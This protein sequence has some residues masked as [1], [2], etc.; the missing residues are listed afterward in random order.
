MSHTRPADPVAAFAFV[1]GFASVASAQALPSASAHPTSG[2]AGQGEDKT[3]ALHAG[4]YSYGVFSF[5]K[6]LN[7][8]HAD[9]GPAGALG[10][11]VSIGVGVHVERRTLVELDAQ[12]AGAFGQ[13]SV[14][15]T[16]MSV[17]VRQFFS[18]TFYLRGGVRYQR[19]VESD[20][21]VY[22]A[23]QPEG[24]HGVPDS[25]RQR[26]IVSD[27]GPDVSFGNHWQWGSFT[28]GVDWLGAYVPVITTAARSEEVSESTG[29]VASRTPVSTLSSRLD[30]R[31]L[32]LQ[33][34]ATF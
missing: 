16:S 5:P 9:A 27:V 29:K 23:A 32:H 6:K 25:I 17:G 15:T 30:L 1:L 8:S 33:L 26:L 14:A 24:D 28:L 18:D 21:I 4:V 7:D 34:G 22:I 19:L 3:V 2:G 10:A 31:L 13:V 11:G 20:D 12:L